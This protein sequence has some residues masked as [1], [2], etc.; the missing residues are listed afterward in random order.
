MIFF[1]LLFEAYQSPPTFLGRDTPIV[2]GARRNAEVVS[3]AA[4]TDTRP[5][6]T[7]CLTGALA[8]VLIRGHARSHMPLA[9]T[10]AWVWESMLA[11]QKKL[12]KWRRSAK[13]CIAY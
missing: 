6:P 10:G 3:G 13:L 7:R 1:D 2:S 11:S 9:G 4:R 8:P 12:N 5:D